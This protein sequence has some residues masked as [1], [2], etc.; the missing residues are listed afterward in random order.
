MDKNKQSLVRMA[1]E[2]KKL[3]MDD[4][5]TWEE[6]GKH[7]LKSSQ[8]YKEAGKCREYYHMLGWFHFMNVSVDIK[9][10]RAMH[11]RDT[12]KAL[13]K[14]GRKNEYLSIKGL[15]LETLAEKER[16]LK[17][18]ANLY[19]KASIEYSKVRRGTPE[20]EIEEGDLYAQ[21]QK[22][23]HIS[24]TK[25]YEILLK[26]LAKNRNKNRESIIE[27]FRK[28]ADEYKLV[29]D[30]NRSN[31]MMGMHFSEVAATMPPV[32]DRLIALKKAEQL[33]SNTDQEDL[34]HKS[35]AFY[36]RESAFF[37]ADFNK[38]L[39]VLNEAV[40]ELE[41][42]SDK[43]LI[44]DCYGLIEEFKARMVKDPKEKS[45]YFAKASHFYKKDSLT[46]RA[47]FCEAFSKLALIDANS[48]VDEVI[49]LYLQAS[50]ALMA[51]R[52]K[53]LFHKI[54]GNLL[55]MKAIKY[56]LVRENSRRFVEYQIKASE[57]FHKGGFYVEGDYY[58]A[59]AFL[60]MSHHL[61]YPQNA[62]ALHLSIMNFFKVGSIELY[63]LACYQFFTLLS[64]NVQDLNKQEENKKQA[65]MHLKAY[66][67]SQEQKLS[68][69]A[70]TEILNFDPNMVNLLYKAEYYKLL[71]DL[72]RGEPNRESIDIQA[73]KLFDEVI[74]KGG[75]EQKKVAYRGKG[76]LLRDRKKYDES[77]AAFK[78]ASQ[79]YPDSTSLKNEFE[80][81]ERLLVQEYQIS[82]REFEQERKLRIQ[83]QNQ[84]ITQNIAIKNE[85]Q[86]TTFYENIDFETTLLTRLMDI[87]N[88]LE[89]FRKTY[90]DFGEEKLRDTMLFALQNDPRIGELATRET[91]LGEGKTDIHILNPKNNNEKGICE[92]LIWHGGSYYRE[93]KEQ[94]FGNLTERQ[95]YAFLIT[96]FK[97]KEFLEAIKSAHKCIGSSPD[98]QIDSLCKIEL[99]GGNPAKFFS[100]SHTSKW[101][102][103][104][105]T[106][107]L[108]F[109]LS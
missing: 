103:I 69:K 102:T 54:R 22:D 28:C 82:R 11:L 77:Y 58:V 12:L 63:D 43:F 33:F 27:L 107:H 88:R 1:E 57:E 36:L 94:L 84:L 13:R 68:S 67:N 49:D 59:L 60:A 83:Y 37:Q 70:K 8:L 89:E 38:S 26:L 62:E 106:Y 87:G 21:S 93:K 66:I 24:M 25:H 42:T 91:L 10:N 19:K 73:I 17:K 4:N 105:K 108:F 74:S 20:N 95:K 34:K 97:D 46:E 53:Q 30:Q 80:L 71:G 51:K 31:I 2:E 86:T 23:M 18:K 72:E 9:Q 44:D 40:Q 5:T 7:F 48:S 92:C 6:R 65:L 35:R 79:N 50:K 47:E 76:W 109:D 100:S 29:G 98:Y 81:S 55:L 64:G 90:R 61:Q 32:I 41:K 104:I 101:G 96:F 99:D 15:Y 14:S 85:S 16:D 78:Q 75:E 3:A 39:E 56:G 45:L 52:T